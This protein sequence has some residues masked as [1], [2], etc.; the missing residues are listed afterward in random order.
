M[1]IDKW[2]GMCYNHIYKYILYIRGTYNMNINFNKA[3][4]IYWS[5]KL[6]CNYLQRYIIIHS[7]IYYELN[8][9][10]ISDKQFDDVSKQL[11]KLSK[12]TNNYS[13]TE[14]YYVFKN[15]TGETGF[16][17]YDNLR[18]EDKKYLLHIAKYILKIY[19]KGG[20]DV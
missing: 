17:L 5:N 6:K 1:G 18:K 11:I 15:F 2:V 14:Y 12:Q 19:L 3:P 16:Y 9:S 13:E 10:V 7:I 4:V 8:N 20:N